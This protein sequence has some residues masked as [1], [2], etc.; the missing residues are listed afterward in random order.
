MIDHVHPDETPRKESMDVRSP[1]R[2]SGPGVKN[3]MAAVIGS[4]G[5]AGATR[6]FAARTGRASHRGCWLQQVQGAGRG[7]GFAVI[8][9]ILS[10]SAGELIC[11]SRRHLFP[12]S[13]TL[14]LP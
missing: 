1:C 6:A 13:P 12:Y 8:Q 11:L 9:A 3:A 10:F 14:Y 2:K 7:A 4:F 5:P